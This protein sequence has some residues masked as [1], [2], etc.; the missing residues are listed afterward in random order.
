[1]R[2]VFIEQESQL[3]GVEYTTLRVVQGLDKSKFEPVIICPVEGDLPRLAREAGV[4]VDIVPLPKFPS[5]SFFRKNRYIANPFGFFISA[6]NVFRSVDLLKQY[7]NANIVDIVITKGLLAHFYGGM[8]AH[9]L[10]I[11][12]IW[13]MQEEVDTKRA[14]GLYRL[15]LTIGAKTLPAKIIVDAEALLE[16]FGKVRKYDDQFLVIYNGVDTQIFAPF[17]LQERKNARDN[18]GIPENILVIGQAGRLI[19]I[20]GQAVLLKA[21]TL[22]TRDFPEIHLL[23]V[24]APL[25]G[26][27]DYLYELQN[28]VIKLDLKERVHFSG[29]LP[30]VRQGL[31]A[32]DIFVN[33]SVES[34]SP[35][36]VMEAM[37]CGLPVVVSSVRGTAE[38]IEQGNDALAFLPGDSN[39]LAIC[40]ARLIRD[41]QLRKD[42]GAQARISVTQKFSLQACVARL[43]AL[44]E[45]VHAT[46]NVICA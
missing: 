18:L 15:L 38:M 34:D 43:E 10:G 46:K 42:M 1:M 39:A 3:G 12:C 28:Q 14:A 7:L 23:L 29:F 30:D 37:S 9:R 5:V 36:S 31:A 25:F 4:K 40:L 20:K 13:Y 6:L 41:G 33:A 22:L 8:A 2:I 17:P 21:F 26:N 19:P 45:D 27:D 32:M 44:L 24:G 35:V 16:Q 11:S